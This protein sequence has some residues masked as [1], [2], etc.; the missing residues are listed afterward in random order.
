MIAL[1]SDWLSTPL[2]SPPNR[3]RFVTVLQAL[4]EW[5]CFGRSSTILH[6]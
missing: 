4:T 1:V 2:G 6:G 5:F 3:K